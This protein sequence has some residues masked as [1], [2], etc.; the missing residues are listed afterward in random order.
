MGVGMNERV[1]SLRSVEMQ[2]VKGLQKA[3][4]WQ[5]CELYGSA[6]F[7]VRLVWKSYDEDCQR[8]EQANENPEG[9]GCGPLERM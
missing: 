8:H 5:D 2:L 3:R 9:Q 4:C 1:N 6:L 7:H